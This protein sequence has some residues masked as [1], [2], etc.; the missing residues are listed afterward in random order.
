[1]ASSDTPSALNEPEPEP[2]HVGVKTVWRESPTAVKSLLVGTAVNRL[3]G[4]IQVFMVLYMTQRGFTDTQAGAALGVYGAGTVL[5]VLTG[6]WMSDRIGPRLTIMSTLVSSAVLLPAVL[7]LDS[8]PAILAIIG[9]GGALSQAYRPASTSMISQLIPA[10][11]QVMI[12]AMVRLAINLGTTAAPL[13]GAALVQVSWDFLFWGEAVA[14]L[15]FATVAGVTLPRKEESAAGEKGA[16]ATESGVPGGRK[17][18]YLAVL[19]DGRYVLFLLAMFA[20]SLIYIQYVSTLPLTVKHLGLSTAVYAAM[21]AL[22]GA[23]VITCEL[24]VAKVVQRWPAR[25]AVIAGVALTGIGMSLY[26]LPWGLAALVIATLVWSLGEIVG[27]PTLFF[28]Y[29]A[30]AGPPELRG[31]YL[32]ASNSLYGLGTAVGPFVGVML[33][34]KFG[35]GLWLGCGAVGLLAVGAAWLG[36]RPPEAAGRQPR[37]TEPAGDAGSV[38]S[39]GT[40]TEA[41]VGK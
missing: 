37:R 7:Y 35:D 30:Q 32:G 1:M 41:T 5:G 24:L 27:Y 4:F 9:V 23:L 15:V 11:R 29:P 33:W 3:G 6:G 12:F 26:A 34:N 2:V 39:L 20:S 17:P 13:L 16:Q 36:V 10:E 40:D 8:Y 28:A 19:A 25:I 31:R 21:V 18:S 38:G 14:I 22:N